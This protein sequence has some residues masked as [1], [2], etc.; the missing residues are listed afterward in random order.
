M[1]EEAEDSRRRGLGVGDEL[2]GLLWLLHFLG[3]VFR[4][5]CAMSVFVSLLRVELKMEEHTLCFLVLSRHFE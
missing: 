4:Q 5:G 3:A 1:G 2:L